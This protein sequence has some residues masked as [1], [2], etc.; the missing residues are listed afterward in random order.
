VTFKF[1]VN[2]LTIALIAGGILATIVQYKKVVKVFNVADKSDFLSS[3]IE[4]EYF[5]FSTVCCAVLAVSLVFPYISRGFG[6]ERAYFQII[7]ILALFF[8]IG[9]IA[10]ARFLKLRAHWLMLLILIPFFVGNAGLVDQMFHRPTPVLNT[11]GHYYND[12]Y[13]HDQDSYA[14]RWLRDNADLKQTKV[15]AD[16]PGGDRLVSQALMYRGYDTGSLFKKDETIDGYIYLR[17]TNVVNGEFFGPGGKV[18]GLTELQDK[19][20]GK[21]KVYTNGG[22]E[23][24]R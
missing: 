24:Y 13:I 8:G 10:L 20:A 11:E 21:N 3:K 14:A 12:Y 16:G 5:V 19:F 22:S 4:G 15:Y 23:I 18:Y 17:Y 2:W 9:A 7:G 6:M 1:V